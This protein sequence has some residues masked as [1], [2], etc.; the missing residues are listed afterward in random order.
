MNIQP[1]GPEAI[2]AR[3]EQ[4][5]AQL[6]LNAPSR[7][8]T[9]SDPT[10]SLSGLIGSPDSLKSGG[11]KPL[12]PFAPGVSVA[13]GEALKPMIERAAAEAGV[14]PALFD[15]LVASESSYDPN[16]RSRAGALG[17]SQLM[18]GTAAGLGVTDPFDPWQNLQG[19]ARYLAQMM[20]KFRDPRTA[21]AAYN[22][23]PGA[24]E[25]AGGIPNYPETRAYVEKVMRLYEL[26]RSQ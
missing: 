7:Q 22:A 11:F 13:G 23:G 24:V 16:A 21:L 15:A 20:K 12:S 14:E 18:P 8:P 17:L 10:G 6:G 3:I 2:R 1:M 25:K 26:R 5:R 4:L 9:S 19:G